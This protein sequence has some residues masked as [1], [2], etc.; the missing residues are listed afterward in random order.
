MSYLLLNIPAPPFNKIGFVYIYGLTMALAV[1]AATYVSHVRY[2]A[3]HPERSEESNPIID[4]FIYVVI[5]GFLGARIYHLFTGY[6]WE[7]DGISGVLAIRNGGLSIWGAVIGGAIALY[8][9]AKKR[10]LS[11]LELGDSIAVGLCVG[12]FIGRFGNYFNQELFGKPFNGPWA[13]EVDSEFRPAGYEMYSTFHPTFLYEGL[14]CLAIAGLII[15]LEKRKNW[16]K[17]ASLATYIAFYCLGRVFMEWLRI[18]DAQEIFGLRFNL[19]LSIILSVAA[20][21]WLFKT[22]KQKV[23]LG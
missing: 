7:E 1:L 15:F 14:F 3:R 13:L 5:A 23:S 11:F 17:G 10:K 22:L 20:F 6:D 18:D 19:L 21:A 4:L 2:R 8:F 12:Q 9:L 16:P